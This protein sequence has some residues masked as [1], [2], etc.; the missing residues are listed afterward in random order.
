M[1]T[2]P[3]LML[4]PAFHPGLDT[5]GSGRDA[6]GLA[7]PPAAGWTRA[8]APSSAWKTSTSASTASRPCAT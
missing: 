2:T 7:P 8:T 3:H 5:A 1:R 4:E 6:I